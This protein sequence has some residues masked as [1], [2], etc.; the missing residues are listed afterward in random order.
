MMSKKRHQRCDTCRY[1]NAARKAMWTDASD[2][3]RSYLIA[4]AECRRYA[5]A[6]L[7]DRSLGSIWPHVNANDW[8]GEYQSAQAA[9]LD[10]PTDGT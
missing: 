8:C 9:L 7:N 1:W 10:A 5:P 6:R 2:G 4:H 3:G